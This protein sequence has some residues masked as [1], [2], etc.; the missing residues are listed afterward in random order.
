LEHSFDVEIAKEVGIN[1]AILYNNIKFWCAKNRANEKHFYDGYYWTYN[2]KK[3]F[4]E[5]FPYMTERQIEYAL[6]KL[7]DAKYIIKGKYN[8]N[9]YD[10]TL[11]YA[12]VKQTLEN[13]DT[14]KLLNRDHNIVE[15]I[16]YNKHISKNNGISKDIPS[17]QSAEFQFGVKPTKPG[18]YQNCIAMI[19]DFTEDEKLRGLLIQYLDLCLEMKTLRGK[20]QWKGMLNTLE[21]VQRQCHPHTFEEIIEMSINHGWK[22]FY[23]IND[24]GKGISG[25]RFDEFIRNK[26]DTSKSSNLPPT[27]S[28]EEF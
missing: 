23:P 8:A 15:P 7:I 18:L 10:Q 13:T 11:W 12:D 17:E 14:T 19:Y 22:T 4:A 25:K 1:A 9:A 24:S 28:S 20:N 21:K 27:K 6:K 16:P 26:N 3:A 2:S 5:L